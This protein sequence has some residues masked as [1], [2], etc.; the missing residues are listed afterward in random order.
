MKNALAMVALLAGA[1][2]PTNVNATGCRQVVRVQHVQ[3]AYDYVQPVYAAVYQ[4]IVVP[5]YQNAYSVGY[6]PGQD[7]VAE[8]HALQIEN[9]QLRN[10]ILTRDVQQLRQQRQPQ[11]LT[12]PQ[13]VIQQPVPGPTPDVPP[14]NGGEQ[15]KKK[16]PSPSKEHPGLTF[17]QRSCVSC[18]DASVAKAKGGGRAF[19][20]GGR[21]LTTL[22]GEQRL[23]IFAAVYSGRMPRG[24]AK[25]ATDEEVAALISF[26]D[27]AAASAIK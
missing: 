14:P 15:P 3:Q 25:Q 7:Q 16:E 21:L 11:V 1:C 20:D 17:L 8:K 26:F 22:T 18:H 27:T 19:F 24:S 9:L 5:V 12:Q 10:E 2:L 4:P 13:P 23:E 6:Q